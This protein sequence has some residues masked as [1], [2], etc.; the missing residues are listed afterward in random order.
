MGWALQAKGLPFVEPLLVKSRD[1]GGSRLVVRMFY[2]MG[3][4]SGNELMCLFRTLSSCDL[5]SGARRHWGINFFSKEV[6]TPALF[7]DFSQGS[8]SATKSATL[9]SCVP[10]FLLKLIEFINHNMPQI[11]KIPF[12]DLIFFIMFL[13]DRK[14]LTEP[15]GVSTTSRKACYWKLSSVS[16]YHINKH[17]GGMSRTSVQCRLS[18]PSQI[19]RPIITFI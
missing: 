3:E 16:Q 5:R 4:W 13:F 7:R 18:V 1:E 8:N 6:D 17:C 12:K 2:S 19:K 9:A 14:T 15:F 10:S 11:Q